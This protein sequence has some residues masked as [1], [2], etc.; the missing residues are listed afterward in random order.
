MCSL[1]IFNTAVYLRT[2]L[3]KRRLPDKLMPAQTNKHQ[4]HE[5]EIS[6]DLSGLL[7]RSP[8]T[9]SKWSNWALEI[10]SLFVRSES[11]EEEEEDV[12]K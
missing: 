9:V 10:L 2:N 11:L 1:F 5:R 6:F 3:R 12:S 4:T 8:S 7:C